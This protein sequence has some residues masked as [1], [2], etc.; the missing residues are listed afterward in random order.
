MAEDSA[1]KLLS[2]TVNRHATIMAYNDAFWMMGMLCV[3][4]LPI[5]FL[6]G[7]RTQRPVA[8]PA[9]PAMQRS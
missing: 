4:G 5:L 9:K 2:G 7:G 8:A 6:M 3:V 1:L